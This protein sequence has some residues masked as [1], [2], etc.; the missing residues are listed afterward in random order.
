MASEAQKGVLARRAWLR[1]PDEPTEPMARRRDRRANQLRPLGKPHLSSEPLV[2][3]HMRA[4]SLGRTPFGRRQD[5]HMG[6][7]TGGDR[8][9][10]GRGWRSSQ[11]GAFALLETFVA[12]SPFRPNKWAR[13]R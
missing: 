11:S 13:A 5:R 2:L 6:S 7:A 3:M 10:M 4:A 12:C 9:E 8:H 1:R